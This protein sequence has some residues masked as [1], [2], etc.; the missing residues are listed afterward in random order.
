MGRRN[1][2][3]LSTKCYTPTPSN[4]FLNPTQPFI[5]LGRRK[6]ALWNWNCL[7]WCFAGFE[8]EQGT[9]F[10]NTWPIL[11]FILGDWNCFRN[12]LSRRLTT[13]NCN[14]MAS[15]LSFF[16]DKSLL[17][18]WWRPHADTRTRQLH[19]SVVLYGARCMCWWIASMCC[20]LLC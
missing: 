17:S 15:F 13:G 4:H 7:L 19:F 6:K 18:I 9:I 5:K 10:F 20:A 2:I 8:D 16:P 12:G 1:P 14:L 11:L 3:L